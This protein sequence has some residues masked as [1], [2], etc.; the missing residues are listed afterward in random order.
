[1]DYVSL[2]ES[3]YRAAA[4]D[5]RWL[6]GVLDSASPIFDLGHG[7]G[8]SMQRAT[9]GGAPSAA[10]IG[11]L[12]MAT[13]PAAAPAASEIDPVSY[14][15]LWYP[16]SPVTFISSLIK[17]VSPSM[18]PMMRAYLEAARV[19]DMVGMVGHPKADTAFVFWIG[20]SRRRD[21]TS[22]MRTSLHQARLH[23]ETAL[24][25]RLCSSEAVAVLSPSGSIHDLKAV[26]NPEAL[27]AGTRTIERLLT[28]RGR[29]EGPD[30]LAAWKALVE[31]RWSLVERHDTD[32]KRLYLAFENPPQAIAYRALS[33]LEA[34]VVD[35]SARGLSG[36][37]VA[38]ALGVAESSVSRHLASA[39]TRL[40]FANRTAVLQFA[41]QALRQC[42]TSGPWA[43]T[44]AESA[45]LT[46]V[47]EG[48]SNQAIAARRGTSVNTVAKQVAGLLRKTR[49]P[50]R[51]ALATV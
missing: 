3:C 40:G 10:L 21:V 26:P 47:R 13:D 41:G 38:Y 25:L 45:V 31:G 1:M 18:R 7:C 12:G 20:A 6:S 19:N 29:A 22:G 42:A 46:L 8:F 16:S 23:L 36:K 28:R 44:D 50:S 27:R 11:Q 33:A 35:L 39:A 49:A 37:H 51:R 14:R 2:I 32:G 5:E 48:L 9:T 43:L 4:T 34:K 15:A 30:A 24:R 17:R